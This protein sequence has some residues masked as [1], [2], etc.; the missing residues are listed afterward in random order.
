M[1]SI[2]LAQ[3][4]GPY[5]IIMGLA[6]LFN[7]KLFKKLAKDLSKNIL[8]VY[9]MG[10]FALF[11]GLVLVSVHNLWVADWRVLLTI[12]AWG[13]LVKGF[14]I[15]IA[16]ELAVNWPKKLS[17]KSNSYIIKAV[18]AIIIGIFLM[19]QGFMA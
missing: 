13:A 15:V 2:Y 6:I 18:G 7:L 4:L 16:P 19:Y 17:K 1:N 8:T 9:F 5:F 11:I 14:I 10:V 3:I 12:I